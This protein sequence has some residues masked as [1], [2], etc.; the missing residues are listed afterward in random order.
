MNTHQTIRIGTAALAAGTMLIAPSL[1]VAAANHAVPDRIPCEAFGTDPCAPR[2]RQ[3]TA[4]GLA[5]RFIEARDTWDGEMVRS[6]VADDA[7]IDDFSVVAVDDYLANAEFEQIAGW[8]Y[9]QPECS[10]TVS[11]TPA[12]VVCTYTMENALS[13]ALGV[14]PFVGSSF[15]FMVA[16]GRIQQ[17]VND[18]DL[19]LYSTQVFEVFV[20]WLLDAYPGDFGVMFVHLPNGYVARSTTPEALVLW[21]RHI[22]EFVTAQNPGPA[23]TAVG[24]GCLFVRPGVFACP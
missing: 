18:L 21:E 10:A 9:M 11:G 4:I 22:T 24:G 6:L 16:D 15:E 5:Q 12:K 20:E 2:P 23:A 8:R 1:G 3:V 19:S 13:R 17:V 7:V 14:G